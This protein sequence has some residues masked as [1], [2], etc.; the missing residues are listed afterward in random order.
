MFFINKNE[1]LS[2]L[3]HLILLKNTTKVN[4]FNTVTNIQAYNHYFTTIF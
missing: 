1:H 2:Y 3:T 4:I